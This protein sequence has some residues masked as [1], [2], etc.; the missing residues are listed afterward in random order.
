MKRILVIE[1]DP[2]LGELFV[3]I[4][5]HRGQTVEV[6]E[7][8][9]TAI[10]R[11]QA[12][13]PAYHLLVTDILSSHTSGPFFIASVREV[14][15]GIPI[16]IVTAYPQLANDR[17]VQEQVAACVQKPFET[18]D[19]LRTVR[20][21]VGR[22]TTLRR[23]SHLFLHNRPDRYAVL[24][25]IARLMGSER[26]LHR[27]L[28]LIVELTT[29]VL[30]CE[31]GTIFV[32]DREK[33]DL[34]SRVATGVKGD[35]IRIPQGKGFA[36]EAYQGGKTIVCHDPYADPRFYAK[37]DEQTGFRTR[38]LLA[39]PI[40][41]LKGEVVGAFEVLNKRRGT[42]NDEDAELA[43]AVAVN[44]GIA[45]ENAQLHRLK[46][47]QIVAIQKA[48]LE[49]KDTQ[50]A[51]V[52]SE[53]MASVG[54]LASGIAH[55]VRNQLVTLDF[56]DLIRN[57][58]PEDPTLANYLRHI[59]DARNR[60]IGIVDEISDFSRERTYETC[61][62]DLRQ[63]SNEVLDFVR[64]DGEIGKKRLRLTSRGDAPI[65]VQANADKLKQVLI[66]LLRNATHA[67]GQA[68]GEIRI[69][70]GREEDRA[71]L[72][73]EDDGEGI[74]AEHLDRI[75][76][77]FFTTKAKAGTGLGLHICRQIIERHGGTISCS[78]E[79]GKKTSF[80]ILLPLAPPPPPEKASPD[81]R[82]HSAHAR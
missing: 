43:E 63:I 50:D 65:W 29:L 61:A 64:F 62:V 11:L 5:A 19:L 34:W 40:R 18:E 47:R 51:L 1:P 49:L 25:D 36:G 44:A 28:S 21:I 42:F 4:L 53:R 15:A 39:V 54:R 67:L 74:P 30:S 33:G 27:L 71:V 9:S 70:A 73:V 75:W 79:P 16:L 12:P 52:R 3:Q 26:D 76:E 56:A 2:N 20:K 10:A 8:E 59:L 6:V 78:S 32:A 23:K 38:N 82:P 45:L 13:D 55:E 77:P 22:E 37:V 24:L 14:N 57:R 48:I 31:R 68:R 80:R 58:Y 17:Y 60:V 7:D 81:I 69:V 41:T 46:D 35:T 72:E 66:N